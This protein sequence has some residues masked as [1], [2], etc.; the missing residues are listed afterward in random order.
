VIKT[1]S[2]SAKAAG[3]STDVLVCSLEPW[4]QVRRRIQI[5]V[6]ELIDSDVTM[7]M[8]YVEPSLDV[9][10][11]LYKHR[12]FKLSGR[13]H[14]A[15]QDRVQVLQP[16]KLLPRVVGPLADRLIED[17]VLSVVR[18]C[19]M[20][21]PLMWVNDVNYVGLVRRTGWPAVYDVTDDWLASS[22]LP[23]ER[24]RFLA[25][26]T[27]MLRRAAEVVVCSPGLAASKGVARQVQLIPNGVDVE[28]FAIP[29]PRPADLPP[30]PV[31]LYPGTL[32][33]DRLDLDLCLEIARGLPQVNLVLLGP[34]AMSQESRER[35]A[36]LG[37]ISMPGARPY[38]SMPGYLQH[39][40]VIVVPHRITPFTES[41]DPIK[42][43]ECLA[44]N[45]PTVATAVAGFRELGPPIVI[46]AG[47]GFVDRV[48]EALDGSRRSDGPLQAVPTWKQRAQQLRAV[49]DQ[50]RQ[51]DATGV[52]L[53]I[54]S[55]VPGAA[56]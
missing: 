38:A 6:G 22:M 26:D 44:V 37:N 55:Q 4:S 47:A 18:R 17:Q 3:P 51:Q 45:T 39:A 28:L 13:R 12:P 49:F 53:R 35:L 7:R 54:H 36:A 9:P 16:L 46:A 25:R 19:G 8:V 2:T 42:A 40:D 43:Y 10:L 23:R 33:E 20:T 11:E 1:V 56:R 5:L 48:N 15:H 30:P 50:V 41:L 21:R 34:N 27:E 32:H 31:A 29:Q 52:D 24:T 14:G